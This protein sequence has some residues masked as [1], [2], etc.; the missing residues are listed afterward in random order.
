M[1]TIT[2]AQA[3]NLT[4]NE[5]ISG[6][7]EST[8][9]VDNFYQILP[10]MGI[11]SNAVTYNRELVAG[12]V[13]TY[14][15]GDEITAK[16]ASTTTQVSST[17]T[18][19]I[20]DA[21]V[22]DFVQLTMSNE[23]DQ[24]EQQIKSKAKTAG[25]KYRDMLINGDTG[26]TSTEFDGL[27]QL[28]DAGK[29]IGADATDGD[30]LSFEKLDELLDQI[31]DKDGAV[32]YIIMPRRELR[33]YKTLL[34]ATGGASP[35]DVFTMP[36][37]SQQIAYSGI[38]IFSDDWIPVDQTQG[39]STNASTIIAGTLDDGSHKVGIAGLNSMH[40]FGMNVKALGTSQTHDEELYRVR[41]YAGLGLWNLNGLAI[42]SGII[43]T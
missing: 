25:R 28:V 20:G 10:F 1:A 17:L 29:V 37:G 24:T 4:Q 18:K 35:D 7:I 36:N 2:L 19:I 26:T 43:P 40:D 34:R 42:A 5:L 27:L 3:Q 6:V 12:D 22:D 30:V 14:G 21:H 32:D 16:A 38:P 23:T 13:G 8:I 31:T 15:V 11:G 41:W 33:T 9:T 39:G